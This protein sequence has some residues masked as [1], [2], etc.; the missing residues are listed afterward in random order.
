MPSAASVRLSAS[1]LILGEKTVPLLS[2]SV[3]YFRLARS[4]W[5]P[6]LDALR[7][8]GATMVDVYVP[9]A[10]HERPDGSFDFGS[11][12]PRLDVAHFLK[13]AHELGLHAIVRP[14]PH[15]NSELTLFGIPERVIWNE[16]CQARSPNGARV[17]LPI[18]PLAFPVPSYASNAFHVEAGRWLAAAA[19]ELAPLQWPDGPIVLGQVD[20]E[21]ALYFR[22]G[23]YDQDYH[24]DAVAQY[25]RFLR[26]RYPNDVALRAA[27]GAVGESLANVEPPHELDATTPDELARHLDWAEFQEAMLEAALYRF[28]VTLEKHGLD[29]VPMF[30]NLPL[31]E[32]STP[33]DPK[34]VERAVGFVALDYYHHASEKTRREIARRTSGLAERSRLKNVPAFAAEMAAG[35]APYFPPLSEGDNAFSVLTALAYGLRGLNMY[36]AVTRDRWIGGAIDTD[37]KP[38]ASADFWRRLFSALERTRFHELHRRIDVAVAVPRSFDRLVRVCHAFGALPPTFFA[39][40]GEGAERGALEDGDDPTGGAVLETERFARDLV[41][42]LE[43][44]HVSHAFVGADLLGD[45]SFDPPWTIVVCPGALESELTTLLLDRMRRGRPVSFGPRLPER[46]AAMKPM[47]LHV[48]VT[49]PVGV[50]MLLPAGYAPLAEA[51]DRA[52]VATGAERL[53]AEPTTV[54]STVHVDAAGE[55]RVLFVVNPTE[56]AVEAVVLAPRVRSAR[57]AL[58]SED[59]LVTGEHV[60]VSIEK[61]SVRMLE[62]A[63][64]S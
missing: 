23:P 62:L 61:H 29:R 60:V 12:D 18:P 53:A 31:A 38:R 21:G 52:L 56:S 48:P 63:S 43:R 4:V 36:M 44:M 37:G 25:R 64:S 30:H 26:Q 40:G 22:D 27:H 8:L 1:G 50:P 32:T 42:V 7:R 41:V 3:H 34:R 28:R 5:R 35:F 9:W 20:N 14:G 13:T 57:D 46:T 2:G 33:L 19:T 49:L 6:A 15:I 54:F 47:T 16:A 11:V 17:V 10:V 45:A 59:V 51:V 39:L 55:P 58:T 24:P